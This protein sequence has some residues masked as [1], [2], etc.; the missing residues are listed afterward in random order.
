MSFKPPLKTGY[1]YDVRMRFHEPI[2]AQTEEEYEK[3]YQPEDPRRI[4]WIYDILDR[5]KCLLRMKQIRVCRASAESVL[6]VHSQKYY[7]IILSTAMMEA[8]QLLAQQEMYDS[9]YLSRE[10]YFCSLLSAGALISLAVAVA[11]Q[12]VKDGIAIIRP[13]YVPDIYF[14]QMLRGILWYTRD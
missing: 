13:P 4:F 1:V 11:Q 14:V 10:T 7:N 12:E 8:H 3:E 2:Q 5:S 9:I 6:R